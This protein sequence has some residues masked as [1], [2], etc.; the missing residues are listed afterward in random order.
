MEDI[1]AQSNLS[2]LGHGNATG[3]R[4]RFLHDQH[5]HR[6]WAGHD[7]HYLLHWLVLHH[8]LHLKLSI[9]MPCQC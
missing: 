1:N 6:E 7:L 2:Y 9:E 8:Y 3:C 4:L 5:L